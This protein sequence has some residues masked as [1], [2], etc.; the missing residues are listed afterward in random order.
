MHIH[1]LE[2]CLK[3]FEI[4]TINYKDLN[5]NYEEI[6]SNEIRGLYASYFLT[7]SKKQPKYPS[8]MTKF[9]EMIKPLT[10]KLKDYRL[11]QNKTNKKQLTI[12][13]SANKC[14]QETPFYIEI[15]KLFIYI[16]MFFIHYILSSCSYIYELISDAEM[17]YSIVM[18]FFFHIID[19]YF[20][21]FKSIWRQAKSISDT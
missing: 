18:T 20:V 1:A 3:E 6:L 15:V 10:Y 9:K 14:D 4:K 16:I 2:E 5:S 12:L 7:N 21:I 13:K 11:K 19:Y 8:L 17:Q